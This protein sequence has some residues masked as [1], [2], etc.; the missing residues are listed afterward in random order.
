MK[1]IYLNQI[2]HDVKRYLFFACD[3]SL[4]VVPSLPMLCSF[5]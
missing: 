5:A 4:S 2:I 1:E 3:F